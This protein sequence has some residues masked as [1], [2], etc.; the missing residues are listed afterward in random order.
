MRAA[1][2]GSRHEVTV[3]IPT[4][5]RAA[6][7]HRAVESALNQRSVDVRVIVVDDASDN[8]SRTALRSLVPPSVSILVQPLNLGAPAAR[9]RGTEAATTRL[10]A[11]LDDDDVWEPTHLQA[12]VGAMD[13]HGARWAYGGVR[14]VDSAQQTLRTDPHIP[15]ALALRAL[16]DGN[17]LVTPSSFVVERALALEIGGWDARLR[18]LGDWDFALRLAAR[19]APA[20]APGHTVR[21]V[22]H[23]EAMSR[24]ALGSYPRE[25]VLV[26]HQHTALARSLGARVGTAQLWRLLG[27]EYRHAGMRARSA[28]NFL[29]AAVADRDPIDAARAIKVLARG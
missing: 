4:F 11:Y 24:T 8:D 22:R 10:V 28:H 3:V 5:Q 19:A 1:D 7:A 13:D 6:S 25:L 27:Y 15:G 26:V 12:C 14:W 18:G 17:A 16:L 29:R 2:T 21:Y 9:Q 23:D 20:A